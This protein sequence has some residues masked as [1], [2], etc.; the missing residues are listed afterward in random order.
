[1]KIVT[2]IRVK[3]GYEDEIPKNLPRRISLIIENA[4]LELVD[5]GIIDIRTSVT[6][7]KTKKKK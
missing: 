4:F 2:R 1:M 5:E 3:P 6:G 7:V